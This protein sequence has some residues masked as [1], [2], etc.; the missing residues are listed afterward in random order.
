VVETKKER[1]GGRVGGTKKE[2]RRRRKSIK[3]YICSEIP[4]CK[5]LSCPTK[6]S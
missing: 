1:E 3:N 5:M 4:K 2:R 6:S